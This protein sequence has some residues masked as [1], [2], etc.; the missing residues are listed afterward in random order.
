MIRFH[1]LPPSLFG[2][3]VALLFE[4]QADN[5]RFVEQGPIF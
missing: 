3:E 5:A 4:T 2:V 1:F